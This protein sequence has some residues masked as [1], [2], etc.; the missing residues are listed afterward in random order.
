M[1]T[2]GGK[3]RTLRKEKGL[4][5]SQLSEELNKQF[6]LS[7]DRVMISKWETGFQTPVINTIKCLA[8]YF[9]VSLDYLN[10]DG[11][12]KQ[13]LFAQFPNIMPISK[14]RIPLLGEIACGEPKFADEDRE[15]Y[16]EVGTNIQAD[17]CLRAKGDSMIGARIMDGDIVFVREQNIVDNGE[18]AV[19]LIDNDTTLKR[20]YYYPKQG[21]LVLMAEN[22]AYEPFVYVGEELDEVRIL[23]KAIAF[24]SDVR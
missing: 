1:N 3:I 5:Q 19:V 4:T 8:Q 11:I 12:T 14:H 23:G 17:F 13:D 21:K 24:Q 20:V 15:S 6:N 7:T 9:G 2:L 18:I 16:V 10:G 22:P